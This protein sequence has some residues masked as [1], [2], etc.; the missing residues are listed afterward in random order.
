MQPSNGQYASSLQFA[1]TV[2]HRGNA[3]RGAA[4]PI[5]PRYAMRTGTL[6]SGSQRNHAFSW[7]I[8][9]KL[10]P[11]YQLNNV[12]GLAAIATDYLLIGACVLLAQQTAWLWPV[13]I[14]VIGSRQ[15]ALASLLH[16]SCHKTL[17][18]NRTLNDILGCWLAGLPIFQSYRAYS[19][20]HVF[21][22]HVHLGS[23][24]LDPD[25]RQYIDTGLFRVRDRLDFVR[26]VAKT[27]LLMNIGAYARYLVVQRLAA[28]RGSTPECIGLVVVQSLIAA[29]LTYAAG[30]FGY[31]VFWILPLLTS[32]QVIGW[33]S[34]ISEHYPK[35]R[36]ATLAVQMSRNRFPGLAERMLV[37]HHGDN[38]HLVHHLFVGIPFWNLRAAHAALMDDPV[39]RSANESV[40]GIFTA[41]SGR[42]SILS[43][44]L[45][46]IAQKTAR[47]PAGLDDEA[48]HPVA[49]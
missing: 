35:I 20:S 41:P 40:G 13:S 45:E 42:S 27:V 10:R 1:V 47:E 43:S 28:I 31:L 22:H 39:Y 12:R 2:L 14:L 9:E 25:Y 49:P 23:R 33:L 36:T 34:E 24:E 11:L 19:A 38:Y 8:R 44:I 3:C 32:F 6:P 46:E 48:E 21:R 4:H 17:A 30:P 37:G 26:H 5:E 7:S 15:R 29:V 16:D 18:R